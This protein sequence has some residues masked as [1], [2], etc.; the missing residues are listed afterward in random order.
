[1]SEESAFDLI[2]NYPDN[3]VD[4]T[5]GANAKLLIDAYK[6]M[7]AGDEGALM[8]LLADDCTFIEAATLPYGGVYKGVAGAVEGVGGMFSAWKHLRV[9]IEQIT[10]GGDLVI[11]YMHLVGTARATGKIYEGPTA[12][13]FRFRDGKITEWRPIY[14]DTHAVRVACGIDEA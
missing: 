7:D 3:P 13:L 4:D 10:A 2:Q 9:D 5:A 8:K 14:W 1:M 11:A 6:A 12:E